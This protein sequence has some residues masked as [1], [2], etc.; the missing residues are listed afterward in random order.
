MQGIEFNVVIPARYASSRLPGKPLKLIGGLPMIVRVYQQAAAAG[1]SEVIIATDDERIAAA[2]YE[3]GAR[4]EMTSGE[5][6]SGTDRVAE[7][8]SRLEWPH[9]RI[10]VNVQGDEPLIPPALIRQVAGLLDSHEDAAIATLATPFESAEEYRD[11]NT[12]KVVVDKD[13]FA[14]Y[15]S[16]ARIPWSQ[17]TEFGGLARRHIGLY[18]YRVGQLL[19]IADAPPCSLEI[20]ERLEQLRA[21]WLGLRIVVGDAAERPPIG[22]DTH[23]DLERVRALVDAGT[24]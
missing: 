6:Q 21:L 17:N 14:L 3:H 5:H 2:G 4:V 1:A 7:L 20:S 24:G 19:E 23:E 22:V 9:R 12:A 11:A 8:S 18:S 16:R 15:F 10:V 13:G